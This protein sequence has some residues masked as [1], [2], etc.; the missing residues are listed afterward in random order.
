MALL[1]PLVTDAQQQ[2]TLQEFDQAAGTY[3][4]S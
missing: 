4:C 2:Q 1:K 3:W